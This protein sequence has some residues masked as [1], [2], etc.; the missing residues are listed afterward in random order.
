MPRHPVLCPE[1]ALLDLQDG[2]RFAETIR[3]SGLVHRV[4][5]PDT[6]PLL[7]T[8]DHV[9]KKVLPSRSHPHRTKPTEVGVV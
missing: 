4:N 7:T 6:R 8:R 1:Q 2:A 3:A 9:E 5:G